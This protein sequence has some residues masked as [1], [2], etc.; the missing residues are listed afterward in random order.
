MR[1]TTGPT[2]KDGVKQK[3][4]VFRNSSQPPKVE[5]FVGKLEA[6]IPSMNLFDLVIYINLFSGDVYKPRRPGDAGHRALGA[7]RG[8]TAGLGQVQNH[9]HL[10]HQ[11]HNTITSR[12]L[13]YYTWPHITLDISLSSSWVAFVT[14]VHS[15]LLQGD[16]KSQAD[17]SKQQAASLITPAQ[18]QRPWPG[19]IQVPSLWL[20][21]RAPSRLR[22]SE[23]PQNCWVFSFYIADFWQTFWV[24]WENGSN[25]TNLRLKMSF[26]HLEGWKTTMYHIYTLILQCS[27]H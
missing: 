13:W 24:I 14:P 4:S 7:G 27:C 12:S 18:G 9:L 23:F 2:R 3:H 8:D 17:R 1:P 5:F 6:P 25:W 21:I 22:I 19:P 16:S 10:F 15:L 20:H 26:L 11:V